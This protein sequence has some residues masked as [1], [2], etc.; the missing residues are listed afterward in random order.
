[1][2]FCMVREDEVYQVR[3]LRFYDKYNQPIAK[4]GDNFGVKS[5]GLA[6]KQVL[7]SFDRGDLTDEMAEQMCLLLRESEHR[8]LQ[9]ITDE[10]FY[11]KVLLKIREENKDE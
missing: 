4:A 5:Y 7:K 1:M 2:N 3:E 9:R 11:N 6:V 10:D 8:H